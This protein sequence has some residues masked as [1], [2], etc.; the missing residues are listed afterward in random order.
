MLQSWEMFGKSLFMVTWNLPT[1]QTTCQT[2]CS[3]EDKKKLPTGTF[4][5]RV[6]MSVDGCQG[7]QD[8]ELSL[9]EIR[10][11]LKRAYFFKNRALIID[12]IAKKK[13][14]GEGEE[15]I[16]VTANK[17]WLQRGQ[18]SATKTLG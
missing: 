18:G 15:K 2:N 1:H 14:S 17:L 5:V 4:I 12:D 6:I 16:V 3:T 9:K 13:C 7:A 8:V 10:P 11:D